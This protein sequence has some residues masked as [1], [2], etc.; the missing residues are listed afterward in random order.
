ML[1]LLLQKQMTLTNSDAVPLMGEGANAECKAVGARAPEGQAVLQRKGK[2]RV[3][4][5]VAGSVTSESREP[6]H[7]PSPRRA[8]QVQ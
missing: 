2:P 1:F 8:E 3:A 5:S 4:A 6:P 7:R